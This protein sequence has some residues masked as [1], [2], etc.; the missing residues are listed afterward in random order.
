MARKEEVV[1]DLEIEK[2]WRK[3]ISKGFGLCGIEWVVKMMPCKY[4]DLAYSRLAENEAENEDK[5]LFRLNT[6]I[7]FYGGKLVNGYGCPEHAEK[8]YICEL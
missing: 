5:Y 4:K 3:L 6:G 2:L 8:G 1:I 7:G